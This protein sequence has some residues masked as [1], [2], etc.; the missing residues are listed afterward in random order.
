MGFRDTFLAALATAPRATLTA[1]TDL[2][3]V[4][5]AHVAAAHEAWPEIAVD[6]DAFVA[7]L[8]RR[9]PE[10]AGDAQLRGVRASDVYL[11]L[12]CARGDQG[13][14]AQFERAYFGEIDAAAARTRAGDALATEV[15]QIVRKVLFVTEGS[16]PAAAGEFS[17]RG[18]LRG[19]IRVTATRELIR[20][21]GRDKREIRIGDDSLLDFLSPAHDPELGYIRDLYRNE[22]SDAF[23]AALDA[24]PAKDRSLLRYQLIDGLSIDEIGALNGV[25]RATAA[26]WLAKVRDDLLERT[27]TEVQRRLGIATGDVD[28]ILKLV[29]SRL[30]VSLERVLRP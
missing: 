30:D 4:L 6:D 7:H 29:H 15:K 13:A 19:W 28:S 23:R 8:A 20:L 26:R 3:D 14:M 16:R 11:A 25:H 2:E 10:D 17:G 27:R 22:C 1:I 21:L 9:F 24:L 18:D 12:A 5:V